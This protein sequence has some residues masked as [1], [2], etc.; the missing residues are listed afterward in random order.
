MKT[1]FLCLIAVATLSAS[2]VLAKE[3]EPSK[4]AASHSRATACA[5]E[6]KGLKGE[7]RDKFVAKCLKRG[8][9]DAAHPSHASALEGQQNKMKKCN[10]EAG[11]KALHGDERRAFMSTCLKA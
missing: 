4:S 1:R 6:A 8:D 11:R 3:A 9:A 2:T 10:E 7:E 5:E